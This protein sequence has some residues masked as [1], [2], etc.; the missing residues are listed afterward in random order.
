LR[1]GYLIRERMERVPVQYRATKTKGHDLGQ[2]D[3]GV[4]KWIQL[5]FTVSLQKE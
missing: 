1:E 5:Q 2:I 3:Y 4:S